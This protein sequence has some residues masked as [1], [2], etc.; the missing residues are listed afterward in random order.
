M[1]SRDG[2]GKERLEH[3]WAMPK[4]RIEVFFFFEH[5]K[6]TM[7]HRWQRDDTK[8]TKRP[9]HVIMRRITIKTWDTF[10]CLLLWFCVPYFV[11]GHSLEE[12]KKKNYFLAC[13]NYLVRSREPVRL[14]CG[15]TNL[16]FDFNR[17]RFLL[18]RTQKGQWEWTLRWICHKLTMNWVHDVK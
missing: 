3:A 5:K 10:F 7:R 4:W 6:R 13:N 14:M 17:S 11:F 1:N 8:I 16:T 9:A 12:K 15:E 2:T 18:L